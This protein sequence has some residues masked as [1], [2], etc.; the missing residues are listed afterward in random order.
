MGRMDTALLL[1]ILYLASP[2]RVE[3]ILTTEL[4]IIL[5]I[6]LPVAGTAGSP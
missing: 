2:S 6:T 5:S 1:S 3:T 4:G